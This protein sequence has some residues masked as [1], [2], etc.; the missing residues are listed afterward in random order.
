M[1][2]YM[3][4]T[5]YLDRIH[6]IRFRL[7]YFCPG[8]GQLSHMS[9]S[10]RVIPHFSK[11]FSQPDPIPKTGQRRVLELME[12]GRIFRYQG[13]DFSDAALLEVEFAAMLGCQFSI[14]LNSCGSAL[15]L[16]LKALGVQRNDRIL[17]NGFTLTPVP[18]AIVHVGAQP[19]LVETTNAFHMDT[20]DLVRKARDS[21]ARVLLLSHIRGH[22]CD[23]HEITNICADLGL[24][25]VEDCA[26]TLGA[27][28]DGQAT[29]TF[30]TVGCF[31]AQT[32]KLINSGEGGL[33]VTDDE[34]IA[35]KVLIHYYTRFYA[36][37]Q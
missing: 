30:G 28:W 29:G 10:T 37:A 21:G 27:S 19:V 25:L 17:V 13:G 35:A 24:V 2:Y 1:Q 33:L 9:V 8:V 26:H 14:G 31:S 6:G 15:F 18:S 22:V 7:Q 5:Q 23:M 3:L 4:H 36:S 34:Q 11:D 32:N 20:A 16:A 12:S